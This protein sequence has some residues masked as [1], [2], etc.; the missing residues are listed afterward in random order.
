MLCADA[1]PSAIGH[2]P[3]AIGHRLSAITFHVPRHDLHRFTGLLPRARELTRRR[4]RAMKRI[5]RAVAA[6]KT[7]R[8]ECVAI[9]NAMAG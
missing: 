6:G 9:A 8:S 3:S 5:A 7:P 2:R 4:L 1:V